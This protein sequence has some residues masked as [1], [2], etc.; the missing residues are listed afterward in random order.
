MADDRVWKDKD[1][2]GQSFA[3]EDLSGL[4]L[5]NCRI[6]AVSFRGAD[7]SSTSFEH[8]TG[9]DAEVQSGVD[10]S[11][12]NLREAS[13]AHCDL[14]AAEFANIS[15]YELSFAHCQLGG[16]SLA[17]ADFRLPIGDVSDLTAFTMHHCNFAYGDLSNVYLKGCTLTDNRMIEMQLHNASLEEVILN[18]SDLCNV[19]GTALS[20][21]GADL[22]GAIFNN[23]DPRH[24]D[25][26]GV[27]ITLEQSL[28]LLEPLGVIVCLDERD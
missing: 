17:G 22:R 14:T 10:F 5:L 25:L 4:R 21:Q 19:T 2:S 20:L 9:F 1:L 18:G 16:V 3:G 8:C 24:I 28:Q 7:L 12:A 27:R 6:V 26:E 11:Y 15:G 23:L 13:F